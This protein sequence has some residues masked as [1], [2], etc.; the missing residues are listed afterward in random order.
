[1][2]ADFVRTV[3]KQY[4]LIEL[5]L[6]IKIIRERAFSISNLDGPLSQTQANIPRNSAASNEGETVAPQVREVTRRTAGND[7]NR[8]NVTQAVRLCTG[9]RG[10]PQQGG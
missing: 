2:H 9:C 1:M 7:M 10:S 3:M 4:V 5:N 6:V 8:G